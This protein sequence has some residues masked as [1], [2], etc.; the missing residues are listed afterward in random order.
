MLAR[1]FLL[2]LV[3]I[4]TTNSCSA[5]TPNNLDR[6]SPNANRIVCRITAPACSLA[7]I[8]TSQA[9][10]P[11]PLAFQ[12]YQ[13]K[14]VSRVDQTWKNSHRQIKA[15]IILCFDLMRNGTVQHIE[16]IRSS[17]SHSIDKAASRCV[18]RSAPFDELPSYDPPR[19][20]ASESLKFE[21][22]FRPDLGVDG[23]FGGSRPIYPELQ[24]YRP[25]LVNR[26]DQKWKHSHQQNANYVHVSF[27]VMKDGTVR[28]VKLYQS[29]GNRAIDQAAI[30]CVKKSAPF[31]P[32]P[33]DP[34]YDWTPEYL[35]FLLH[36]KPEPING[37]YVDGNFTGYD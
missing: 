14:L 20:Q 1:L 33:P 18:A 26:V 15:P 8:A 2:W 25:K 7:L 22:T 28:D 24:R 21:I 9:P 10:P 12:D 37:N 23:F 19:R 30:G 17:G 29:S 35:R 36:F 32:L 34:Y 4:A 27:K 5:D 11:P 31:G 3:L 13:H 6:Q 16:I